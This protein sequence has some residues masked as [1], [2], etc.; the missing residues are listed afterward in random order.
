MRTT[1]SPTSDMYT[2]ACFKS[3]PMMSTF[4]V[5]PS[6]VMSSYTKTVLG[7]AFPPPANYCHTKA[8]L[9]SFLNIVLRQISN[10]QTHI[11]IYI[12]QALLQGL[13]KWG[14]LHYICVLQ[15][16]T[17]YC[18]GTI[19]Q[20]FPNLVTGSLRLRLELE[21]LT[22]KRVKVTVREKDKITVREG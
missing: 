7:K 2:S 3:S 15:I 17:L 4:E 19:L 22:V 8:S 9:F 13:K 21:R 12:Y 11:Y 10:P 14:L 20:N 16:S 18:M 5:V 1:K 6:P